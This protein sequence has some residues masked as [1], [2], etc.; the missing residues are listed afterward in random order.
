MYWFQSWFTFTYR[1]ATI[2]TS[3]LQITD[4]MDGIFQLIC[5]FLVV[6]LVHTN[7]TDGKL[8]YVT[9]SQNLSCPQQPCLTLSEL[10]ADSNLSNST[11]V[12]LLF[13][14]GN[15][16]LDHE[17]VLND[18]NYISMTKT[19]GSVLIKCTS[20][21]GRFEINQTAIVSISGLHFMGCGGN[22]VSQV[23]HF[24]LKDTTF[25]G[26]EGSGTALVLNEVVVA[27]IISCS[28]LHN[29]KGNTV[30]GFKV[31]EF[32]LRSFVHSEER[33]AGGAV[34]ATHSNIQVEDT[35]FERN[36][37]DFGMSIFIGKQSNASINN[38]RFF[39]EA[40]PS[41]FG[42]LFVDHDCSVQV[43]NSTFYNNT[44][45]YG[46]ISSFGGT[47]TINDGSMFRSN[48]AM[49]YGGA[50][51]AYNSSVHVSNSIF[52]NNSAGDSGGV[53]GM[54]EGSINISDSTFSN[55][56]AD[57]RGGVIYAMPLVV[58][59]VTN[60]FES[61]VTFTYFEGLF[62]ITSSNFSN[63]AARADGGVL[64]TYS[65]LFHITE[66]TFVGNT[67]VS[68]G[69]V[70][71]TMEGS[72]LIANSLFNNNTAGL[73]GGVMF[74]TEVSFIVA[75]SSFNNNTAESVGGVMYT[76]EGTFHLADISFTANSGGVLVAFNGSFNITNSN[77]SS[78]V[79]E[80]GGVI[81][82][83]GGTFLITNSIFSYSIAIASLGGVVYSANSQIVFTDCNFEKTRTSVGGAMYLY[84]SSV[85]FSGNTSFVDNFGSLFAF[86]SNITFNGFTRFENS[87]EPSNNV[88]FFQEGG[89]IT[90]ILSSLTFAGTSTL[91]NNQGTYGGAILA[92]E[93]TITIFGL[94]LIHI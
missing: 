59:N 66:S 60:E 19:V 49:F 25:Q 35:T 29:T 9:P 34:I 31:P 5:R 33:K 27:S 70:M 41:G 17:L 83:V 55:N 1:R 76:V 65:G 50:V 38:S 2:F 62:H 47:V 21:S 20:W 69:G 40:S 14:P 93:S 8:K 3:F 26:Q 74:A 94:S 15:H 86:G 6:L 48:R 53:I 22:S 4:V 28:Y 18:A 63:N 87:S 37:A 91:I 30:Q 71:F 7:F 52:S 46:V 56:M 67:A 72:F 36:S 75:N 54:Y 90:I 92:I 68:S 39:H 78:N 16:S 42:V 44:I 81:H 88:P 32:I 43:S 51:F 23:N 61:D 80:F 64:F 89:A 13:L 73:V 45:G 84:L 11:N 58:L 10:A 57:F 77:F 82:T 24:T 12:T 79:G 85:N